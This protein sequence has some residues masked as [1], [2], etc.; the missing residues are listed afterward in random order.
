M[1]NKR[2]YQIDLLRFLA[3]ISVV[4]FHYTFRGFNGGQLSKVD[5]HEIENITKYGYLGV[6]LFFIISGFVIILSIQNSSLI[7]FIKSRFIRLYPAYWICLIATSLVIYFF[8]S[9]N[10]ITLY[11]FC[12]NFTMLNG[13]F[14]VND[15]DGSYWS[16]LIEIKFY[17]IIGIILSIPFL[18][19]RI[20]Y[21][22]E[23]WLLCSF[24]YLI[25]IFKNNGWFNLLNEYGILTYNF[26]F[27]AGYYFYT[28]YDKTVFKY[29]AFFMIFLCYGLSI[30]Y[31][32]QRLDN[33]NN[34]YKTIFSPIVITV[35]ISVFYILFLLMSAN[36]LNF[37]NLK[38]FVK[39]GLLTYPLY[40]IHHN[41][42]FIILNNTTAFNRYLVLFLLITFMIFIAYLINE[43]IEKKAALLLKK[44]FK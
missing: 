19:K 12:F 24:I 44:A 41:I 30:W 21:L 37:L 11:Q 4:F 5:Y 32:I 22:M 16:L 40:L 27:I 1:Y 18:K 36:K 6:D 31:A 23:L 10:K 42:G 29:R 33:L 2:L 39:I 26:Y 34:Y 8:D 14:D 38:I 35:S 28:L 20:T 7:N 9:D 3:A 43:F 15:I 13:Y 25:P 17:F